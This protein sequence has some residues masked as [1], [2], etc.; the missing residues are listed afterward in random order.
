[1]ADISLS[2]SACWLLSHSSVTAMDQISQGKN[3]IVEADDCDKVGQ[4]N[5]NARSNDSCYIDMVEIV[6]EE[7]QRA[8]NRRDREYENARRCEDI[9]EKAMAKLGDCEAAYNAACED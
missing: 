7:L 2:V 4:L 8:K 6:R 5:E 1:M 9:A 3:S